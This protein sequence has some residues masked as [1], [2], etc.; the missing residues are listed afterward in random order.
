MESD[1][2]KLATSVL[3][4]IYTDYQ[5]EKRYRRYSWWAYIL[6]TLFIIWTV[7]SSLLNSPLVGQIGDSPKKNKQEPFVPVVEVMGLIG[8]DETNYT[9]MNQL[10]EKAFAIEEAPGVIIHIDSGGGAPYDCYE[11]TRK[12][13]ELK[14]KYPEK[15]IIA[16]VG[17]VA[18][19]GGY[20]IAS[21]CDKIYASEPSVLGSIGVIMQ[22]LQ[23]NH[24]LENYNI[25]PHVLQAGKDKASVHPLKD[26]TPEGKEE[27][28]EMLDAHHEI[29]IKTVK[30]GRGDRLHF[31]KEDLFTGKVWLGSRSKELGLID[32]LGLMHEM[33]KEEFGDDIKTRVLEIDYSLDFKQLLRKKPKIKIEGPDLH[34]HTQAL[35]KW[36]GP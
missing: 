1:N 11:V 6:I 32:N 25:M 16:Q 15:K 14:A 34:E 22:Y 5:R 29:F 18:A 20:F 35:Y 33:V 30:R 9:S 24:F 8:S 27:I 3:T 17:S 23:F 2:D 12:I 19:S 36:N 10:I 4:Q 28:K 21:A 7:I 26:L 31:D 13:W